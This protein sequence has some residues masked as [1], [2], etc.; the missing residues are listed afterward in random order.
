M[1]AGKKF[2]SNEMIGQTNPYSDDLPNTYVLECL[3]K[4]EKRWAKGIWKGD[5]IERKFI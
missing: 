2:T 3:K 5:N 4:L 1:S